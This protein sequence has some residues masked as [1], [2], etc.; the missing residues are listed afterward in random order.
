MSLSKGGVKVSPLSIPRIPRWP[1]KWPPKQKINIISLSCKLGSKIKHGNRG[2]Q[3][4]GIQ[5]LP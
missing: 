4:Q 3:G 1:P 2:F 5:K